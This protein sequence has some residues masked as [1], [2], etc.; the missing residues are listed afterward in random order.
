LKGQI[1]DQGLLIEQDNLVAIKWYTKAA[2][3]GSARAQLYLGLMYDIGAGITQDFISAHLWYTL[4]M[5]Q[6][7]LSESEHFF[8]LSRQADL[9]EALS[10]EEYEIYQMRFRRCTLSRYNDCE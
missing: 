6:G 9:A 10:E 8:A 4:A 2:T 5:A 7:V 3:Q 1:Y